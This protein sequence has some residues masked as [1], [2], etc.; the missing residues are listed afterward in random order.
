LPLDHEFRV[1]GKVVKMS[2]MI[3]NLMK[4]VNTKEECTWVLWSLQHYLPT[5]AEWLNQHNER[6][7]IERLVQIETEEKIVGAACGGNHRLFA[8]TRT[9]DKYLK[10]GGR[11]RGIWLLADQKIKQHI[12]IA[13]SLQNSDG[14]FSSESY[15]GPGFE[16]DVNKRFNTTGHTMEFLSI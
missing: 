10:N 4:E 12:E 11:L 16:N 5:D 1:Q 2:D 9:R 13:R 15:K 3:N 8:L 14:S 7:S 6:W